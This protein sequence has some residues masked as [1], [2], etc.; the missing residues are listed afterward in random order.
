MIKN[1]NISNKLNI[2][3]VAVSLISL[4]ISF[5][6]LQW[7]SIQIEE[8]V[9]KIFINDLRATATSK[10]IDKKRVGIS[11]AVSIANDGYIK[12]ALKTH[13]RQRA[14]ESLKDLQKKFQKE[15]PFKNIKVHIHTKDNHSF[16]RSW[17][18]S[19]YGDDLSS[20]RNSVVKVNSTKESV[21]TFELGKAG[22]SLRSVV[23][24]VD[25][26]GSHLGSLE[27]MQGLNSV[28]KELAKDKDGFLV[29]V[30]KSTLNIKT[31][32]DKKLFQNRYIISQKFIEQKFFDD[33]QNIDLESLLKLGYIKTTNYLV[34]YIDIKDFRNNTLGIALVGT[35]LEKLDVA[36]SSNTK[37]I[38]LSIVLNIIMI[39][40]I[41]FILT[42]S[43]RRIVLVPLKSLNNGILQLVSSSSADQ[44]LRVEVHSKDEV[45]EIATNFNKYLQKIDDGLKQDRKVIDETND[46]LQKVSNGFLG[47]Q[48]TATASNHNVEELK[49][50]LNTMIRNLK[51]IIDKI[52]TT[53]RNYS[54]SKF[55]YEIDDTN[56]FGDLGLLTSSIKLV[57]NNT[58][59]LLA[60]VLRTGNKLQEDI[61]ILTEA[62]ASLAKS[63]HEQAT[64]GRD[65]TV[66]LDSIT[67][68]IEENT[69]KTI[70]M[71]NIA[72]KVTKSA[73]HGKNLATS[74]SNAMDEIT[75]EVNMITEAIKV[76][77]QIAFQTNILS[78]NAAVE[79]ATAGEAG[80]GFAVV[81]QEVRNLANR[82]AEAAKD[83]K[84]I[85]EDA[86]HKANEGK[87]I[88]NTMIEGYNG[89]SDDIQDTI[90]IIEE[91]SSSSRKQEQSILKINTAVTRMSRATKDNANVS[92]DISK[93]SEEVS[94]VATGLV[95]TAHKAS[96]LES[97]QNQ[98]CDIDLMYSIA[99]IKVN[100]LNYTDEIF[101]RLAS[102]DNTSIKKCTTLMEW[103]EKS[104]NIGKLDKQ[105][106]DKLSQLNNSLYNTL[107]ELMNSTR[108]NHS[109]DTINQNAKQVERYTHE[110]FE[111]LDKLKEIDCQ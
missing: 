89:L 74:T 67:K 10:L 23:P 19:K 37:I 79:A 6:V 87:S 14:I 35:P 54:Q 9:K 31:F 43:I 110:I 63:V 42:I 22:L 93:M 46:I 13:N 73:L 7:Y 65:T 25:N 12:E 62:S 95:N 111:M 20:F 101:S 52:N 1:M 68:I 28:A 53:V 57:G 103:I 49:I 99:D 77:D 75:N 78:L 27:F 33:I 92:E 60:V 91:V 51:S 86:T 16:I 59:E 82:S 58:S 15:T 70:R 29:L 109:N 41:I 94:S 38:N 102:G 81:A 96:F 104:T 72:Q 18:L 71:S 66:A 98:V 50:K 36:I 56:I 24:V 34:T 88:A 83:I 69:E 44:N 21:N 17:K 80:K 8:D 61:D 90:H 108:N 84:A 100:I 106:L 97:T 5:V 39:G 11:N 40:F 85:V 107:K 3:V 2:T 26:D 48:V 32:A 47:Y 30:D 4:I 45:G 105:Y 64:T 55:D 76:I